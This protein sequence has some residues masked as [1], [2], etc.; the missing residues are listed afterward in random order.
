M[1]KMMKRWQLTGTGLNNLTLADVPVP[2]PGDHEV[3]IRVSAVSL[4][5]RDLLVIDGK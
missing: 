2:V 4:N 1:Q 5:Y 3:L